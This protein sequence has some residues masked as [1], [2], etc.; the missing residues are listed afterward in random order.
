MVNGDCFEL[1][2]EIKFINDVLTHLMLG[3][4]IFLMSAN[5]SYYGDTEKNLAEN[6][7]KWHFFHLSGKNTKISNI[8]V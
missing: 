8:F 7:Q 5:Y 4:H 2:Y 6:G 3:M 1:I